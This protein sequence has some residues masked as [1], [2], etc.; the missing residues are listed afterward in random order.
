MSIAVKKLNP[1]LIVGVQIDRFKPCVL[2]LLTR[3]DRRFGHDTG[4]TSGLRG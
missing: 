3:V 4:H 2:A 1:H